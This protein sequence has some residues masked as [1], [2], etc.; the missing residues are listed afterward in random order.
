[1]GQNKI[2]VSATG[3]IDFCGAG[4]YESRIIASKP[5]GSIII[6]RDIYLSKD[7]FG[8]RNI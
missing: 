8:G 6:C 3:T 7:P 1:M 5:N 4:G 2:T